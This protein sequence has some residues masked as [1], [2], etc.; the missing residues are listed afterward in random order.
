MEIKR[1][2]SLDKEELAAI[3]QVLP[4]LEDLENL[5]T[6]P[7]KLIFSDG[8]EIDS[9]TISDCYDLLI[10]L[11]EQEYNPMAVKEE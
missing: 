2:V 8:F 10:R 6:P 1:S 4:I 9:D 7:R 11:Y 3:D 5:V